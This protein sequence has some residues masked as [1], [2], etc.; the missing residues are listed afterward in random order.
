MVAEKEPNES[1]PRRRIRQSWSVAAATYVGCCFTDMEP[2]RDL[3]RRRDVVHVAR[4]GPLSTLAN[5]GPFRAASASPSGL[6]SSPTR[7]RSFAFG[8][9]WLIPSFA[10]RT[11]KHAEP[12]AASRLDVC[13]RDAKII[14]QSLP[15]SIGELSTTCSLQSAE[16]P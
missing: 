14:I 9:S 8:L 7:T 6:N 12:V 11:A 15:G 13:M 1:R 4:D 16:G 3:R 10:R 2:D 5:S